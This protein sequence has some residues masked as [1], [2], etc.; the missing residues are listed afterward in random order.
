MADL[1]ASDVTVTVGP[2]CTDMMHFNRVVYPTLEFGDG[3]LTYPAGGIP[4]PNLGYFKLYKQINFA[5]AVVSG[6]YI[7][8]IDIANHKLLIYYGDYSAGADGP[9][10]EFVGAPAATSVKL[11]VEGQ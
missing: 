2:G 7:Y 3:A 6:G 4:L 8:V 9:L 1:A 10:V 11:K 5:P